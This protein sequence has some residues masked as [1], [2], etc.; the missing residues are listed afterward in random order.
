[1]P[2]GGL[3]CI[4]MSKKEASTVSVVGSAERLGFKDFWVCK[5]SEVWDSVVQV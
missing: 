5:L 2:S 1:M 4:L 3:P